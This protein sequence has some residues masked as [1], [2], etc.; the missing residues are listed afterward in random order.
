MT[1]DS[2]G[3]DGLSSDSCSKGILLTDRDEV[4]PATEA[5][6]LETIQNWSL[7]DNLI[8][9]GYAVSWMLVHLVVTKA[10]PSVPLFLCSCHSFILLNLPPLTLVPSSP[11]LS[12][13][14]F[15][16]ILFFF[17]LFTFFCRYLHLP[18]TVVGVDE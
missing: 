3:W 6:C 8:T 13:Q 5:G 1:S 4:G 16:F 14:V 15:F 18:Q 12:L 7:L 10:P 9:L 11:S 2:V 17:I